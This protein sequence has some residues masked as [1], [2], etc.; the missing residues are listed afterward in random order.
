[1]SRERKGRV[2]WFTKSPSPPRS[3]LPA[4]SRAT[5]IAEGLPCAAEDSEGGHAAGLRPGSRTCTSEG[6]RPAQ[7]LMWVD[8]VRLLRFALTHDQDRALR[9]TEELHRV[10]A[11]P[12]Q[13]EQ[14]EFREP[15]TTGDYQAYAQFFGKAKNLVCGVALPVVGA[16]DDPAHLL[17]EQDQGSYPFAL[18]EVLVP[19]SLV[20]ARVRPLGSCLNGVC[21][22]QFRA[23]GVGELDGCPRGRSRLL[24]AV[25]S[26]QYLRWIHS[27]ES[28]HTVAPV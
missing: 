26:Q 15:S 25:G 3:P 27:L 7:G 17:V 22:V 5:A 10:A 12:E 19:C 8:R 4:R 18:E 21:H 11:R 16:C 13:P 2:P 24:G 6:Y 1:M 20:A 23:G 9:A 14:S 28:S